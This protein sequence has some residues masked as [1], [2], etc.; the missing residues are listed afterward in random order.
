MD[1]SKQHVVSKGE[2]EDTAYGLN[3]GGVGEE[4][5]G[6]APP[7]ESE[8]CVFNVLLV[9]G[10][11]AI[12]F[13]GLFHFTNI[14]ELLDFRSEVTVQERTEEGAE[15]I[16]S[17][18][19][20]EALSLFKEILK[21]DPD[22]APLWYY[23]GVALVRLERPEEALEALEKAVEI[24]PGYEQAW[25]VMGMTLGALGREEEAKEAFEQ[26]VE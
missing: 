13:W 14:V 19:N 12:I 18:K 1:D 10:V 4:G 26:A 3:G 16:E 9:V 11:L 8:G 21:E 24:K 25:H 23:K 7:E 20:S 17:G 5:Q 6:D 15:L 22:Y 2:N